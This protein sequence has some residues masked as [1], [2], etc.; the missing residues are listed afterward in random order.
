M[1]SLSEIRLLAQSSLRYRRQ[2]LALKHYFSRHGT[3]VL[4]LDDRTTE[5]SDKTTHSLVHGVI[6][7]EELTPNYG[8]ERRRLRVSKYR[9]QTFRGGYHDFVIRKGGVT[10]FPRLVASEHR[11]GFVRRLINPV[12]DPLSELARR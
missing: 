1:D 4:L 2:I 9:G 12:A 7:L 5:A 3:T 6:M 10:V 11:T 8:A